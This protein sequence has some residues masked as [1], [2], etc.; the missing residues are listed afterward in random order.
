M[1]TETNGT[2]RQIPSP[3][4][5]CPSVSVGREDYDVTKHSGDQVSDD[6]ALF[7]D[8][9]FDAVIGEIEQRVERVAVERLSFGR[10]LDLDE[11]RPSPV[12][13]TFMSTSALESSSYARSR[14]GSPSTMPTLI[15]AT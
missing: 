6:G 7:F 4:L 2:A 13:T 15:A 12:L 1:V 11:L 3:K 14:S 5:L 10:A 8:Q 9:L